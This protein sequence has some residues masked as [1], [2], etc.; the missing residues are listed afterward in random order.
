MARWLKEAI[1]EAER[2]E[3]EAH[4]RATVEA[5]L[6]DV[7]RRGD[8]AVR[9]MSARF[10]Q[11]EREDFRL[12]PAEIEACLGELSAQDLDD[13]RFA[14]AQVRNFALI[15]RASLKDVEE[16]TLP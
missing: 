14:Q 9:E 5:A 16:E 3:E 12:S 6:A 2:R 13:I 8:D 1:G 11:W 7:E 10:D 15:Q 4:G